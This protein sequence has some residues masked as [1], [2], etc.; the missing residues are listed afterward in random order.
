MKHKLT[1]MESIVTLD[2]E[3]K[4]ELVMAKNLRACSTPFRPQV[5]VHMDFIDLRGC[6]HVMLTNFG[7]FFNHH[8]VQ[9]LSDTPHP[10]HG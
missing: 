4:E 10:I 6:S 2:A 8:N 7:D 9:H 3:R 5:F 1:E